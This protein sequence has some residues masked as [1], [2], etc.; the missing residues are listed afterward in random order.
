MFWSKKK[1]LER[2][3]ELSGMF[4]DNTIPNINYHIEL[5]ILLWL[6]VIEI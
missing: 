3:K 5:N 4:G 2:D 6:V 1:A